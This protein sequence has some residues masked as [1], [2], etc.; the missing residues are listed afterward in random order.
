MNQLIEEQQ[1]ACKKPGKLPVQVF[2]NLAHCACGHKMYVRSKSPKYVCRK[3]NNKIP[4]VDLE[5]IFQEEL[6]AFFANPEGIAQHLQAAN[7]NLS[8]KQTLLAAHEREIDK[9]RD[10]MT[11]THR[12]YLDGQITSQGFGQF[13][14]SASPQRKNSTNSFPHS[15]SCKPK[16]ISSK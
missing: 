13:Y 15:R 16:S 3:C 14:K 6:K 8:E 1:K 4:I 9:M 10:E 11:R 7:Q 12:L 5:G 2:G